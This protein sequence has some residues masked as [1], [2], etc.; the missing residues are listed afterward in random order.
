MAVDTVSMEKT[1]LQSP[2]S[3]QWV[4]FTENVIFTHNND[5]LED[6][7]SQTHFW[8]RFAENV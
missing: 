8:I 7:E 3:N 2:Y 1:K 6:V 4:E 5:E